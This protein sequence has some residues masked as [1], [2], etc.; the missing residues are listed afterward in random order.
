MEKDVTHLCLFFPATDLHFRH[1]ASNLMGD[2]K[3]RMDVV[4]F[5][6]NLVKTAVEYFFA[7]IIPAYHFISTYV[8]TSS[9]FF[10]SSTSL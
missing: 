10:P 1:L 6:E 2:W 5:F 3:E 7:K 9:W 4:F 8:H